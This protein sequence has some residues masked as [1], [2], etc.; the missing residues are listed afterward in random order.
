MAKAFGAQLK[1]LNEVVMDAGWCAR[2]PNLTGRVMQ[3]RDG[4][5]YS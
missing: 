5:L 2:R 3:V 1:L 4:G